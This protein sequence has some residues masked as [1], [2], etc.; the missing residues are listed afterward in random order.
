MSFG[1]APDKDEAKLDMLAK[2]DAIVTVLEAAGELRAQEI[3]E[4]LNEPVS[5]V[6][7]LLR[8]LQQ[9][10]WV[11]KR[12]RSRYRLGLF[13][14][15][16]GSAFADHLDLRAAARPA[17]ER[18][19]TETGATSYLSIRRGT[20]AV[21]IE[22][23]DGDR[24]Q[25]VAMQLGNSLPLWAGAAAMTILAFLAD[26]EREDALDLLYENEKSDV[27][28]SKLLDEV[29]AIRERGYAI[30]DA[31]LMPGIAAVGAPIFNHRG[32]LVASISISGL[33]QQ[34]L[35]EI[36]TNAAR[37]LSAASQ[38]SKALGFVVDGRT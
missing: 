22:R 29:A 4:R 37:V 1:D 18:L 15:R 33:R 28:R 11:D 26:S 30:S 12:T 6:Y 10:G 27:P 23:V 21:C 17:L 31:D 20:S 34:F 16:I 25:S 2:V 13:F 3:A 32:E 5:S 7:R 19:R 35:E 9:L 38:I 24:V 8:Q 14:L 36:D